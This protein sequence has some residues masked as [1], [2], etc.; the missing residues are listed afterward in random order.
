M[1][2]S[3]VLTLVVSAALLAACGDSNGPSNPAPT[4][5]F[6]S[7]CTLLDCTFTDGSTDASGGTIASYAWDFGD[8]TSGTANTATT[9]DAAH[10]FS[11]A[12]TFS[13]KLTVTDNGGATNSITKQVVAGTAPTAAFTSACTDLTCTFTDQS[14]DSD[15][16]GSIATYSWNF[17]DN[18]AASTVKNPPAHAYAA[19]GTYTVTLTVTDNAGNSDNVSNDVTVTAPVAGAPTARF[20]VNCISSDCS[21][22]ESSTDVSPGTVTGWAWDFGDGTSSSVQNPPAHH[23][24][25]SG[26]TTFTIKLTVTDNDGLTGTASKLITVAPAAGLTCNG[27]SCTLGL[28]VNSTVLVTLETVDCQA[29]GNTFVVT[30]PITDTLFTDGCF[31]TAGTTFPLD[32]GGNP[33]FNAG[34]QLDAEVLSGVSGVANS[35]PQLMVTGDFATGW[36]LNFDDGFVG[37]GEPDFNDLVIKIKATPSP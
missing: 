16:G 11:A 27:S 10:T 22:T 20:T 14:T 36:T 25:V 29:H 5:A 28:D 26:V 34:T 7:S 33:V 2:S 30:A 32:N 15:V 13:V 21:V 37:V 3:R 6:T 19:A 17:G 31:A 8:P 18:S 12:G 24:T 1:R 4:A 23:Y 35:G 9:K